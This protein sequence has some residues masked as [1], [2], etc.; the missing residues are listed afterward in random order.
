MPERRDIEIAELL[1]L[2]VM[3]GVGELGEAV[4]GHGRVA[5]FAQGAQE[6]VA[7]HPRG[8]LLGEVL[9]WV[10]E[11]LPGGAVAGVQHQPVV[12]REAVFDADSVEQRQEGIE[13][14]AADVTGRPLPVLAADRLAQRRPH[15]A[16]AALQPDIGVGS[17]HQ[18]ERGG[19]LHRD[20]DVRARTRGRLVAPV[21]ADHRRGGGGEAGHRVR[22]M[23]GSACGRIVGA[24]GYL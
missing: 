3:L 11:V 23:R 8:Q 21:Q 6:V 5:A 20:I 4:G 10:V 24:A 1:G 15:G 16:L 19:F 7:V 14:V 2:L 22:G 13:P 12:G 17:L 18:L 9:E